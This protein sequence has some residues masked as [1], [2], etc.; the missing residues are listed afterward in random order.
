M[1]ISSWWRALEIGDFVADIGIMLGRAAEFWGK[2]PEHVQKKAVHLAGIG[3]NDETD[4]QDN[5]ADLILYL[6][7]EKGSVDR[8]TLHALTQLSL[9]LS[10]RERRRYILILGNMPDKEIKT[11]MPQ[12]DKEG[13]P[14]LDK[15]GN[16]LPPKVV[17][18]S[19]SS[20][21]PVLEELAGMVNDSQYGIKAA[22]EWLVANRLI[23]ERT[24]GQAVMEKIEKT[25]AATKKAAGAITKK[26]AKK[27][28]DPNDVVSD[29]W[30]DK[31]VASH[32]ARLARADNSWLKKILW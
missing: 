28:A 7:K 2:L 6:K 13:N 15:K 10:E 24:V 12:V 1:G 26:W 5:L 18:V 29:G 32:N 4:Q 14:K 17:T 27:P 23:L 21:V 16:P 8:A 22:R 25:L 9:A 19:M 30:L 20:A 3:I 11:E 31:S